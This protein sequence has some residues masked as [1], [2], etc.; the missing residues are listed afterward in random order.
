MRSHYSIVIPL[1]NEEVNLP[2]LYQRLQ[3][4]MEAVPGQWEVVLIDDGSRDRTLECL[5]QL[6]QQDER[7]CYLSFA[8]NFGHQ[9]AVTAGLNFARGD[10]VIIMDGDLQDPP[11]LIPEMI[12]LWQQGYAV[13]YAQRTRRYQ[14]GWFKRL[15]AYVFAAT[16]C[17]C[18]NSA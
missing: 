9:T 6:H 15:T 1:Y 18:R 4:L 16:A 3:A 2:V 13:I 7:I 17:R 8:R 10:A 14:E 5:R 11:E 12:K